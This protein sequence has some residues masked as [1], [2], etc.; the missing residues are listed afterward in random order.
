MSPAAHALDRRLHSLRAGHDA[1]TTALGELEG[2][3]TY[4]LLAVRGGL[5]G[6]TA[7][8]LR[9]ALDRLVELRPGLPLLQEL[10]E[11]ASGLRSS[12]SMDDHRATELV[13]L[14]NSPSL[15]VPLPSAGPQATR[16]V[17]PQDL[18]DSLERAIEPLRGLVG[19]VADAWRSLPAQL[20][21]ATAEADRLAFD[22]P[23]VRSVADARTKLADLPPRVVHDLSLIHI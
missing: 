17:A 3:E 8:R 5:S 1:V 21:E 19:D 13:S 10:I 15:V 16:T 18:L 23:S 22:M 2:D 7:A 4:Q 9:P 20:E 14:L 11:W 12:T 6:T